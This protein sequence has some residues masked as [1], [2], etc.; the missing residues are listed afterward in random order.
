VTISAVW[1]GSSADWSV[2]GETVPSG[3][4][5]NFSSMLDMVPL[6]T[7]TVAV[8]GDYRIAAPQPENP[9]SE[10]QQFFLAGHQDR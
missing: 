10:R 3:D 9:G 5:S 8:A 4:N 7:G 6:W 1:K 2:V